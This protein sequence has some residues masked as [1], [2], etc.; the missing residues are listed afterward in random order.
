VQ[1]SASSKVLLLRFYCN[2]KFNY[3]FITALQSFIAA[4]QTANILM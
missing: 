3:Y 1:K 2:E 4:L